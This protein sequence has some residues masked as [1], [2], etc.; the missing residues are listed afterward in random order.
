MSIAQLRNEIGKALIGAVLSLLM[1]GVLAVATGAWGLFEKK[2]D[3]NEDYLKLNAK[4]DRVLDIACDATRAIPHA[5]T[6]QY[7]IYPRP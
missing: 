5:C 6:N 2:A 4:I 1:A 3:H 7:P